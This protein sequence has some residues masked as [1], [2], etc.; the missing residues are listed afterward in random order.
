[1]R[2]IFANKG[3][4]RLSGHLRAGIQSQTLPLVYADDVNP[5]MGQLSST[6]LGIGFALS[7]YLGART[8]LGL[9]VKWLPGLGVSTGPTGAT[10]LKNGFSYEATVG[11]QHLLDKNWSIGLFANLQGA[12]VTGLLPDLDANPLPFEASNSETSLQLIAGY[13]F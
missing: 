10:A 5:R 11:A 7:S 6:N 4:L 1:M 3:P 8:R 13:Q 2:R 9:T 12:K